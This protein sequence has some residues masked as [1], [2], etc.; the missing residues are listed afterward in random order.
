MNK[1]SEQTYFWKLLQEHKITIPIIQRDYAQ[2]RRG[3]EDLRRNFLNE[4][5]AA[6]TNNNKELTLHFVYG[7]ERDGAIQ[8]LDGQQRLTT[9]WLLH[10]YYCFRENDASMIEVLKKFSYETRTSSKEFLTKMC[11]ALSNSN[12]SFEKFKKSGKKSGKE[13]GK[14][15]GYTIANYIQDQTW[16]YAG[17]TQDP[18]IQ[19]ILRM[20]SGTV[21]KDKK[22]TIEN[23]DGIEQVFKSDAKSLKKLFVEGCPI[24]F[25]YLD[26]VGIQQTDDLYV[27]MNAR[28]EQLTSFENF[29]AD[30]IDALGKADA[31]KVYVNLDDNNDKCILKKLDSTWSDLFW[32]NCRKIQLQKQTNKDGDNVK[33]QMDTIDEAFFTFIKRFVLN[34]Y[35]CRNIDSG[36]KVSLK[37]LNDEAKETLKFLKDGEKTEY[38]DFKNYKKL[39]IE[40]DPKCIYRLAMI[41]DSVSEQCVNLS[42]CI[43]EIPLL[44]NKKYSYLPIYQFDEKTKM[45]NVSSVSFQDRIMNYG[46]DSYLLAS[47]DYSEKSLKHWLRV[48]ANLVYGIEVPNEDE[49]LRRLV[50]IKKVAKVVFNGGKKDIYNVSLDSLIDPSSTKDN[51]ENQLLEEKKKIDI[52]NRNSVSEVTLMKLES[53]WIFEGNISCLLYND[54]LAWEGLYVFLSKMIDGKHNPG[55]NENLRKLL[56]GILCYYE[57]SAPFI[58]MN[59]NHNG[60]RRLFNGKFREALKNLLKAVKNENEVDGIIKEFNKN[61]WRKALID[62]VKDNKTWEWSNTWKVAK[63]GN[64]VFL[65]QGTYYR[66]EKVI[67]LIGLQ[68]NNP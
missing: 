63:V 38:T 47:G 2:G 42:K 52:I 55:E 59:D 68:Q 6:L 46:I 15:E 7:T 9:L 65:Y 43:G 30:L 66:N 28:G 37:N 44:G 18:T 61:D 41:L 23:G 50:F 51:A 4:L 11:D 27:K 1:I 16:F 31:F 32:N 53:L 17:W 24:K 64:E 35:I 58:V 5:H 45:V 40:T 49:F 54:L 12:F 33:K 8:P 13:E 29:K 20:L 67:N 57:E 19:S 60:F 62:N 22:E 10:W 48:L 34:D 39:L 56:K 26:M 36:K 3:K 14:E 21:T 25:F